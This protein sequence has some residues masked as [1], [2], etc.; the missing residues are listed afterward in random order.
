MPMVPCVRCARFYKVKAVGVTFEEG[1]PTENGWRGYK[2]WAGD[3]YECEGCGAQ[4]VIGV[5]QQPLAEHYQPGYVDRV[6]KANPVCRVN[7]CT[8]AFNPEKAA[9]LQGGA[10]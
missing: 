5:A 8:G 10:S 2:L 1:F 9:V 6:A 7:D 4:A 3:L